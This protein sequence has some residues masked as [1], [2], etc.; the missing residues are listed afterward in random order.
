MRDI[1][2]GGVKHERGYALGSRVLLG[3]GWVELQ[4]VRPSRL[5]AHSKLGSV[6]VSLDA[7]RRPGSRFWWFAFQARAD[8]VEAQAARAD[9]IGEP[10]R[11]GDFIPRID[12]ERTGVADS[13]DPLCG[14]QMAHPGVV[15]NRVQLR[16][17]LL[18]RFRDMTIIGVHR[19]WRWQTRNA[20]GSSAFSAL[21]NSR[22]VAIDAPDDRGLQVRTMLEASALRVFFRFVVYSV[23]IGQVPLIAKPARVTASR[24]VSQPVLAVPSSSSVSAWRKA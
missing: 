20:V 22:R 8:L 1:V 5:I 3:S 6:P 21:I 15:D 11:V 13:G 12:V 23:R 19:Q 16:Y 9:A 17:T 10:G 4:H 7:Q 2:P 24:N 18:P 14:A